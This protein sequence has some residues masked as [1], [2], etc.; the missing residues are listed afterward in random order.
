MKY[1]QVGHQIPVGRA[2]AAVDDYMLLS[3]K[4]K[5]ANGNKSASRN[6]G[7]SLSTVTSQSGEYAWH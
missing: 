4:D 1:L 5:G 6:L 3:M 2:E 7:L